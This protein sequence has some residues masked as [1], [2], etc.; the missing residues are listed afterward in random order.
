[1][2]L[3]LLWGGWLLTHLRCGDWVVLDWTSVE[4]GTVFAVGLV[5]WVSILLVKTEALLLSIDE[6]M[7]SIWAVQYTMIGR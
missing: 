2:A 7:K 6:Q 5:G 4:S 3:W 1:M